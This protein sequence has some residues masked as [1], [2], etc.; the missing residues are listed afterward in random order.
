M[1]ADLGAWWSDRT[2]GAPPALV[3]CAERYLEPGWPAEPFALGA[4]GLR[5][6]EVTLRLGPDRRAALD[7][8]A[9]DAL[10]T[11]ALQAEAELAPHRLVT[12]A[13]TLRHL[14]SGTA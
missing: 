3:R 10:V 5:A 1:S 11:S 4:A 6:L 14:A 7:L 8:L 9:A 13:R 12:S 2:A